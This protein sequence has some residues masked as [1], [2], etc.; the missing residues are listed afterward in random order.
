MIKNT[1]IQQGVFIFWYYLIKGSDLIFNTFRLII[2]LT[3]T[4]LKKP[5]KWP[6]KEIPA[7]GT[8]PF[9]KLK[10]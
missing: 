1:L 9:K 2:K 5:P 4:P 6:A 10:K 3:K 8:K 7:W